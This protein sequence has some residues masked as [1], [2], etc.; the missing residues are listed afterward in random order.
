MNIYIAPK[1]ECGFETKWMC[2]RG[3]YIINHGLSLQNNITLV[4]N[5]DAADYIFWYYRPHNN[6]QKTRELIEQ[7]DKSKLVVI[8]WTDEPDEVHTEK[9][10]AY[11]KRSWV[12][13]E[14]T[15]WGGVAK[16]SSRHRPSNWFP[17]AY[18]II[19]DFICEEQEKTIDIGCYL[20][21]SCPNRS[22]VKGYISD[23]CRF[24]PK[25]LRTTIGAI[26]NSSRS[27]GNT[28]YCDNVYNKTL[29]QTKILITCNPTFWEGDSRTWEG[30]A[31]KCLVFVDR[32]FTPYANKPIDGK[33]WIEYDVDDIE[34]LCIK[35]NYYLSHMEEANQIAQ[36]GYDFAMKHH[37]PCARVKYIL[38]TIQGDIYY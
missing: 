32:T 7:Y 9:C 4:N 12:F 5:P 28:V 24:T 23:F 18:S 22:I 37:T 13:P 29:A 25:T 1:P 30:L 2:P 38:D 8:D 21:D 27:V 36:N 19:D 6:S 15:N 33:H 14:H 31:N 20:R 3:E 10:L 34:G 16:K 11:F 26:T 35:L 17:F